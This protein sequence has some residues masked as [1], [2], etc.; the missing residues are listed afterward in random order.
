M[1]SWKEEKIKETEGR[2]KEENEGRKLGWKREETRYMGQIY[3]QE[4]REESR[5]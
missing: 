4:R 2:K 5:K 3:G 1:S